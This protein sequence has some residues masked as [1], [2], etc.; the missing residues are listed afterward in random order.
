MPKQGSHGVHLGVAGGAVAA[1]TMDFLEHGRRRRQR[2][3]R[4]AVGLRDQYGEVAFLR[5]GPDELRRI[6][7]LPVERAPIGPVETRAEAAHA[8]AD[9][10][11]DVLAGVIVVGSNGLAH[12]SPRPAMD[13]GKAPAGRFFGS[14]QRQ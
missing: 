13:S 10:P 2:Q 9:I 8:L 11:V 1:G 7:P 6:G 12:G 5:Q 4:A 3:A 14:L